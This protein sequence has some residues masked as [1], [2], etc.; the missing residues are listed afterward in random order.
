MVKRLG[1]GSFEFQHGFQRFNLHRLT[2]HASS[3]VTLASVT[4]VRS[5]TTVSSDAQWRATTEGLTDI[6]RHV[7]GCHFTQEMRLQNALGEQYL[8]GPR[9]YHEWHCPPGASPQRCQVHH[10]HHAESLQCQ[11]PHAGAHGAHTRQVAHDNIVTGG[12]GGVLEHERDAI[13]GQVEKRRRR[14][15]P[16]SAAAA[17]AAA[18]TAGASAGCGRCHQMGCRC[19]RQ[20]GCRLVERPILAGPATVR[21]RVTREP[22]HT[23]C[24]GRRRRGARGGEVPG[25]VPGDKWG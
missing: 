8:S 15:A 5:H 2:E 3:A 20:V 17:A 18:A 7:I 24:D 13:V 1:P 25:V 12:E 22:G 6:A 16:A 4:L 14:A 10:S 21:P 23:H 9:P 19:G 11:L